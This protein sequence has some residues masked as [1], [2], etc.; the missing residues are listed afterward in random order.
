MD[1]TEKSTKTYANKGIEHYWNTLYVLK[2]SNFT[3]LFTKYFVEVSYWPVLAE[4]RSL[5]VISHSDYL[6][7]HPL[8][9]SL[10]NSLHV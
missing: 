1:T 8:H 4:S 9:L 7:T 5:A 6:D 10:V 2:I 3:K